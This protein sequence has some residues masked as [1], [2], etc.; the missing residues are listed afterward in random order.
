MSAS[1][2]A[3]TGEN[4]GVVFNEQSRRIVV[5]RLTEAEDDLL[6]EIQDVT[7][8]AVVAVADF[9]FQRGGAVTVGLGGDDSY[10]IEVVRVGR[11][12][13]GRIAILPGSEIVGLPDD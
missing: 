10:Q 11:G 3:R 9:V 6:D 8:T 1:G 7:D 5:G 2:N 4:L 12:R 13:A